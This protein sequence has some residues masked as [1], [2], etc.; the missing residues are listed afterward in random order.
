MSKEKQLQVVID[1]VEG[2]ISGAE[3]EEVFYNEEGLKSLLS[4]PSLGW[5]DTY[6]ETNP[7][8]FILT[9]NAE[10]LLGALNIQDAPELFLKKKNIDCNPTR[11]YSDC[12]NLLLDCQ[13][14]WVDIDGEYFMNYIMPIK[15][16]MKEDELKKYLKEK[17]RTKF[18]YFKKPP[19]WIQSANQW[20]IRN[21]EPLVFVGSI[22]V[23]KSDYFHDSGIVYI[24]FDPSTKSFES[25][26]QLA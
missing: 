24:F 13:P 1:F 21:N 22:K 4:D 3:F 2:K 14:D 26:L 23:E 25:L 16:N 6:I 18:R 7:Y 17:I 5:G 10:S 19:N 20:P 11:K 9:Q 12:H 15:H 8:D